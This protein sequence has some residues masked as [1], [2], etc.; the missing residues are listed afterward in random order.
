MWLRGETKVFTVIP[1]SPVWSSPVPTPPTPLPLLSPHLLLFLFCS[2]RPLQSC[3]SFF[4]FWIHHPPLILGPLHLLLTSP[5]VCM[6]Q[7]SPSGV[8]LMLLSQSYFSWLSFT[9]VV[10]SQNTGPLPCFIFSMTL[11]PTWHTVYYTSLWSVSLTR[12]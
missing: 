2:L 5:E 8:Y 1:K 3:W 4:C 11:I 7:P 6:A 12:R 10:R 9:K